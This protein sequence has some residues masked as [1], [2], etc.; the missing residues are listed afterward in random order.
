MWRNKAINE[1]SLPMEGQII[2]SIQKLFLEH[3]QP[4]VLVLTSVP[5]R[6]SARWCCPSQGML[7]LNY[8]AA[9]GDL[10]SCIAVVAR[11]WRGKLMFACPKR[12][13]TNV[14]VQA[15][16]NAILWAIH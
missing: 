10:S 15:E 11:D 6:N 2:K 5:T 16:A 3:W 9:V 1:K 7:K 13:N 14:P 4:K 8:D 12:V